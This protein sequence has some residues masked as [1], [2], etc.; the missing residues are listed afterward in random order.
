VK[1]GTVPG[2]L[3]LNPPDPGTDLA[4]DLTYLGREVTSPRG[5]RLA[6]GQPYR[7]GF[8]GFEPAIAWTVR[9]WKL[10]PG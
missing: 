2:E 5:R 8:A 9:F 10:D 3:V 7:F 4:V 6:A 1:T